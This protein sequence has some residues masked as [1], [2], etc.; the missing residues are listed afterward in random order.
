MPGVSA[1]LKNSDRSFEASVL[2]VVGD[3]RVDSTG[4]AAVECT[5]F[6]VY[7][8]FFS[9]MGGDRGDCTGGDGSG[10]WNGF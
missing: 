4:A 7:C 2:W 3:F 5:L 1:W 10:L 9:G 8:G 6:A